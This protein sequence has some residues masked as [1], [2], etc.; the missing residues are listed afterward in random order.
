M[1]RI[2]FH[3]PKVF[4]STGESSIQVFKFTFFSQFI[5]LFF[6][7]F[8]WIVLISAEKNLALVKQG[9]GI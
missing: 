4:L 1:S 5:S 2:I 9:W 3:F 8:M 6:I 7:R